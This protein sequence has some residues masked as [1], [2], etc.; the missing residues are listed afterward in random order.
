VAAA[1]TAVGLVRV[2][3]RTQFRGFRHFG[4]I[5]GVGILFCWAA[6]YLVL[7]AALAALAARGHAA[8]RSPARFG[9]GLTWADA[10]PPAGDR[11]HRA[12]GPGRVG[13][14]RVALREE[15]AVR[16]RL[17]EPALHRRADD[18]DA[19]LAGKHRSRFGRGISGGTVI[20]LPTRERAHEVAERIRAADRARP[21]AERMFSRVSTLD[22]LVPPDQDD[23]SRCS[24]TSASC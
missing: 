22:D 6:T 4:L 15:P 3:A 9:K 13:D 24:P 10:A 8:G 23:G 14:L 2:A 7:P 11:H 21:A 17:P 18:G 20:A 19:A 12:H 16:T 1:L 5:G